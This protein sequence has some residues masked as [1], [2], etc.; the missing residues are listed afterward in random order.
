MGRLF[1]RKIPW[2][3]TLIEGLLMNLL[4]RLLLICVAMTCTSLTA[5]QAPGEPVD[6]EPPPPIPPIP[7]KVQGEE[8][9]P[10]VDIRTEEGKI[11]EEYSMN[12][13]VYMVKV[14]PEHG[15]PYYYLDDDGDGQ[16]ELQPGDEAMNPVQP[17][18]WKLKEWK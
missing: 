13:R 17:V 8:L 5:W 18:Y 15:V 9:E 10:T 11:V 6:I 14:T 4:S 3:A 7:P 2:L 16:L 1:R 12:G